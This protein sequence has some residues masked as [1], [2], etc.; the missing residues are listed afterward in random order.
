[1]DFT[2]PEDKTIFRG[3]IHNY[4][5]QNEKTHFN[6]LDITNPLANTVTID[7]IEYYFKYLN[8]N[9]KS[10]GGN[11]IILELFVSQNIDVDEIEYGK[12]DFILKILNN[13]TNI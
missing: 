7:N 2:F 12:P 9:P 4:Q 1:M 13:I 5:S 6:E 10:K 11:S 3:N 8:D